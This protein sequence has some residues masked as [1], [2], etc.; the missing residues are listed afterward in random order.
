MTPRNFNDTGFVLKAVDYKEADAIVTIYSQKFGKLVLI[1]NGIKKLKS[2]KRGHIRQFSKIRFSASHT[3]GL[4]I[5][6][7]VETIK[8][9]PKI[10]KTLGKVSLGYYFSEVID[11]FIHEGESN[12]EVFELIDEYFLKLSQT[13]QLKKLR[14][15]FIYDLLVTLGFWPKGK[16]MENEDLIIGEILER[17]ISSLRVG[18][19]ILI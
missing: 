10:E 6:T 8:N 14:L 18:K 13:N 7:E 2:R 4:G 16:V 12:K 5:L 1:A 19:R 9:Y 11:K 3:K 17:E 15:S